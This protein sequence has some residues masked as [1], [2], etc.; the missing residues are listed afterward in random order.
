MKVK[1]QKCQEV[2]DTDEKQSRILEDAILK[3]KKKLIFLECPI[4]CKDS[5]VD[6]FNLLNEQDEKKITD[7]VIECPICHDG[8]ISY[9]DDGKEKFWGCGECG[10]VWHSKDSLDA[11]LLKKN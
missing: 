5:Y 9:I 10:N 8:I 4:C 11:A 1:C 2:F 3:N 6:P 7:E